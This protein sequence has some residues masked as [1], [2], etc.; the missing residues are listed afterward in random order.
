MSKLLRTKYM[1]TFT[2]YSSFCQHYEKLPM[3]RR[4]PGTF[5]NERHMMLRTASVFMMVPFTSFIA[6][7]PIHSLCS[8]QKVNT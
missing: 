8:P 6:H 4:H 3:S 5:F 1:K 7:N 2:K